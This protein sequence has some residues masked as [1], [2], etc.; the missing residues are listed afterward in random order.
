MATRRISSAYLAT[1]SR[2]AFLTT[3]RTRLHFAPRLRISA[4]RQLHVSSMRYQQAAVAN[5][6]VKRDPAPKIDRGASKIYEDADEAVADIQSGAMILSAGFGLC[7]TAGEIFRSLLPYRLHIFLTRYVY[8]E[9]II[10]A[11][12]RRGKDELHSLTAV[13]NNAGTASGGGLSPLVESGQVDRFIL[14]FLGNNK[15][16][17]KKYLAG[18]IAIELCPQGTIA[19]RIRAGGAGIPAF[20]TPTG[21][22]KS[23]PDIYDEGI[24]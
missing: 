15:A 21:V 16:L 6:S 9:T 7:G 1:S 5:T 13:S 8:P 3:P 22:S 12:E 4:A 14:S 10:A 23:C 18:E 24:Y 19:E 2:N 17:E 20:F 11:I